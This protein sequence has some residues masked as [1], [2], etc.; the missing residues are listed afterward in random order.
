GLSA[1]AKRADALARGLGQAASG[2]DRIAG[3]VK[4]AAPQTKR[5]ATGV[6]QTGTGAHAIRKNT[7][8]AKAG[9]RKLRKNIKELARSLHNENSSSDV[10]LNGPLDRA[11]SAVQSALRSMSQV[12]PTTA[13]DPRFQRAREH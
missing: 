13:S 6:K 3:G 1:G 11:Q 10:K 9:T 7:R 5:L 12:L 8:R 4:R 2:S